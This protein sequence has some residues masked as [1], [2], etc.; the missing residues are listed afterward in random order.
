[1][2][3]STGRKDQKAQPAGD[4]VTISTRDEI[5]E[6]AYAGLD[7]ASFYAVWNLLSQYSH[8]L[9]MSFT[10]TENNGRGSGLPN[11][12]D[13]DYMTTTASLAADTLHNATNLMTDAF[14]DAQSV[15]NGIESKFTPG[16]KANAPDGT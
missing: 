7:K 1:M 12:A 11:Q 13:L 10:T 2:V 4:N 9:P 5:I 6:H 16:P 15:R 3:S 8:V 14:P